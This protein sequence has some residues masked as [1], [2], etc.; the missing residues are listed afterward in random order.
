MAERINQIGRQLNY[1]KG[2][3]AGQVAIITGSGQGIGAECARLFAN[4]GAKVVVSD[5]D[6][7]KA[8]DVAAKIR[9]NGGEALAVAGDLLKDEHI[10]ELVKKAAEFG[11]GKIHIIVNNAGFTWDAVIHK[12]CYPPGIPP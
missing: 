4:E 11:N 12:V 5:I 1:P 7:G 3:L 2:L 6:A 10:R 9:A 8:D